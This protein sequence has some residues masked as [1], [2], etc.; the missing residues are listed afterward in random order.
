MLV[1]DEFD[2]VVRRLR[3]EN[4]IFSDREAT[5]LVAIKIVDMNAKRL[6]RR[7]KGKKA[8]YY[9]KTSLFI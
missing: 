3:R 9:N 5:R 8:K 4:L 1:D 2:K 6:G 7:K